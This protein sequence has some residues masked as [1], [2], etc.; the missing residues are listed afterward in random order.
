[1]EKYLDKNLSAKE[2]AEDLL[3]KMSVAEKMGQIVCLFPQT[4]TDYIEK[5]KDYPQGAGHVSALE[6][7]MLKSVEDA[8]EMQHNIQKAVIN[9]SEH[10]IPAIF[11]MEGISGLYLK[12]AVSF[13]SGIAR[14]ASFNPDIEERI[15]K[16]VGEGASAAGIAQILAPVLDVS[17]DPRMGRYGEPYGEDPTLVAVMGSAYVKGLQEKENKNLMPESAAKHFLGFH[18]SI[19]GV[20]GTECDVSESRLREIYAKPFQAAINES[21]LRG[22]MPCYNVLNGAPVSAS[23]KIM[24]GLLRDEMGFD[25]ITVADYC[26]ISN[27]HET[28]KVADSFTS[29]GATAISAG[30]DV[31]LQIKRCYNDELAKMFE[32]GELDIEILN[33]AVR[34]VLEAK[35]RMGL[36][37]HPFAMTPE[38]IKEVLSD[39][40]KEQLSLQSALESIVLIK[41]DGTL[42]LKKNIKKLAVIGYHAGTARPNFNGYTHYAMS[43]GM[44]SAM[45]TM[46]GLETGN[47]KGAECYEGSNV[48]KEDKVKKDFENLLY[49]MYPNVKTLFEELKE[50]LKNTRISYSFGYPYAGSDTSYHNDAIDMAKD[51]EVIIMTVGGKYGTG[52]MNSTSEGVDSTDINLPLCQEILIEKLS[53]L[54]KPIILVHLD[55]RPISSDASDKYASAILEAWSPAQFGSRAIADVLLGEYNPGG[56]LPVTVAYHS[57]QIPIVYNHY[58]ASSYHQGGSIG[59][60]SYADI[61]HAPRY[62]F[63]HGLSYTDFQ[64]S[65]LH[66]NNNPATAD[67][68]IEISMKIKNAGIA[69]GDEIVQFYISDKYAKRSRPVMELAGFKRIRLKPDEEKR[70]IFTFNPE[71]TAFFNNQSE[72]EIEA[73]DVEIMLG[74]SSGDIRLQDIIRVATSK[75]IDGKNRRLYSD[76]AIK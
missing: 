72:W 3:G 25:G 23:E 22:V 52:G 17:H 73:G 41:N 57:G 13:P 32:N 54:N 7:R 59:L 34:R 66:I 42:P 4:K 1:M 76:A 53:K 56:K 45:S 43:E 16:A 36:F 12:D 63:G 70:V 15:A 75:K 74:S 44:L 39:S 35:F 47:M 18:R 8:V 65:D 33:K 46:A 29:A 28:Q 14:G 61:T 11:H 5:L 50:R 71:Q 27:L 19:G 40:E 49:E 68:D 62:Y 9:L 6:M 38:K 64:Y 24:N 26:A 10:K 21:G 20:H 37:E 69:A 48:I 55:G 51:A 58:N 2:R 30:L 67:E 60:S 31:E